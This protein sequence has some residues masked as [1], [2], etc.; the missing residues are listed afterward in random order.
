MTQIAKI[1]NVSYGHGIV[2]WVILCFFAVIASSPTAAQK[3]G[4]VVDDRVYLDYAD[5]VSYDQMKRSGVQVLKG[6]V[7]FTYQGD[8]LTCDSA[9]F[10]QDSNTFEAFGHVKLSRTDGTGLTCVRLYYYGQTRTTKA[11]QDVVLTQ[12]RRSLHCDSLDYNENLGHANYFGGRGRLVADGTTVLAD[13]GDYNTNTKEAH[14]TGNV[15]MTSPKYNI[16]TPT[17]FYNT[18]TQ[19][20]RVVGPSV[21]RSKKGEVVHTNNGTYDMQADHMELHGRSTVTS[22]DRDIEGDELTYNSTSGDGEGHGNVKLFDKKNDRTITGENV[23][24]NSNTGES[25]G[26]GNVKVHDR[27]NQRDISGEHLKYNSQTKEG[28][29]RGKVVFID[30]KNKN[31][32]EGDTI[33]YTE[34][35][36][37]AYGRALAKDFSEGDT[38]FVH[39][40][41]VRM[42]AWNLNTDSVYRKIYGINN[43]RAYRTDLQAVAGLM[44]GNSLDS[45]MTLYKDPIVWNGNR[46]L[47]G[48]SIKVYLQERKVREA[49]VYGNAFSVE[50]MNDQ[51]HYNQVSSKIMHGYF[52]DGKIRWGECVGNVLSVYY[53]VDDKDSTI[54]LCNYLETDTLRFY[55][56]PERKLQKIWASKSNGNSYPLHMIPAGKER[57]PNFAWYDYIRPL[58]QYDLFR[59]VGKG[60]NKKQYFMSRVVLPEQQLLEGKHEPTSAP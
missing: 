19:L 39:A 23:W 41:T 54:I 11:R 13:L 1:N 36:A 6:N 45:C 47:L 17:L 46:Q 55:F 48:D 29:G 7:R 32:F 18:D 60:D 5:N 56:T 40:D 30:Y 51:K 44:I 35:A 22:P 53:P 12:P 31:A 34:S 37:I 28:L 15:V 26:L 10:N 49:H 21:I 59:R 38:L 8:K 14:F 20:A 25:E 57:L 4:K 16:K 2:K 50:L 24:Y 52:V 27:K 58:N 33:D 43:V 9:F 42:R 3:R